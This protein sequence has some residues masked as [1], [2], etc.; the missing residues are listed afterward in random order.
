MS[1]LL[2]THTFAWFCLNSSLPSR[3]RTMIEDYDA[4]IFVSAMSAY[5]MS[6]K[7]RLGLWPDAGALVDSFNTIID[8]A[9]FTALPIMAGHA[10]RA[11]ALPLVHRDPF[12]RIIAAHAIAE[13]LSVVSKDGQLAALGARVVWE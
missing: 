4:D 1:L 2:D 7:Y 9:H 12:D 3:V 6:L 13:G 5:E 11:G 10:L 8:E